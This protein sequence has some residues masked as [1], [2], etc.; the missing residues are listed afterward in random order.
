MD[1]SEYIGIDILLNSGD[2]LKIICKSV[3][4]S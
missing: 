2:H 1:L 4:I 3:I